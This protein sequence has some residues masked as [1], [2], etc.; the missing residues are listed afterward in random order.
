MGKSPL[1]DEEEL[2]LLLPRGQKDNLSVNVLGMKYLAKDEKK[3]VN[4][5][6]QKQCFL[7]KKEKMPAG[8][9]L[10]KAVWNVMDM[11]HAFG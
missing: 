2:D 9:L 10:A 6:C 7:S 8:R 1:V 5:L 4:K 11:F 3:N